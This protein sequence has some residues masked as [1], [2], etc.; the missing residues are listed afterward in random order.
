MKKFTNITI[1]FLFISAMSFA[2]TKD[3]EPV[4]NLSF[5]TIPFNRVALGSWYD[6]DYIVS[7][8]NLTEDLTI[9]LPNVAGQG[10][11]IRKF[12]ETSWQFSITLEQTNGT[13]PET[14]IEVLCAPME[15]IFYS[16]IVTH[17]SGSSLIELPVS[18]T[19]IANGENFV[20]IHP[21]EINFGNVAL[22]SD[23]IVPFFYHF[24]NENILTRTVQY[25]SAQGFTDEDGCDVIYTNA[26][27]RDCYVI[28]TPASVGFFEGDF[29]VVSP[30]GLIGTLH[31]TAY[32]VIPAISLNAENYDFG[33][34]EIDNYSPEYTYTVTGTTLVDNI[35]ITAPF[36]FEISLTSGT[37]F[38]DQ[39]ILQ[40]IDGNIEDTQIFVR[41]AP[42]TPTPFSG[43][44]LHE[45]NHGQ[46]Q[47]IALSGKGVPVGT[48]IISIN[49]I[50]LEFEETPVGSVSEE[51][52]YI[53]SAI[54]LLDDITINAPEGFEISETS[55]TNF[56][57]EIIL[58][59]GETI[60]DTEIFVRF[61]PQNNQ[62]YSDIITNIS[63][64]ATQRD[65]TVSGNGLT[66]INNIAE[67]NFTIYPNPS[68]GIFT[69]NYDA[70]R[71]YRR[72]QVKITDI[73]GKI[74]YKEQFTIHNSQ[75]TINLTN[76]PAGIY[77]LNIQTETDIYTKKII[78]Q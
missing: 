19:G 37:D 73:T 57:N 74:I 61:A 14:I 58:T 11:R 68:N 1:L 13:I 12:G 7:A 69:I 52:V 41:F 40:E 60:T 62:L 34:V 66:G 67:T 30:T 3:N 27:F 75:F 71:S 48:P 24:V 56:S 53:I 4:I 23:S 54:N 25:P 51:Q 43:N 47:T 49:K 76:Q 28:F 44:I 16:T 10:F 72:L 9:S 42:Q 64:D 77:F 55:E 70:T 5:D 18:G 33:D 39:I 38:T 29:T 26:T 6:L 46:T 31:L 36:G 8:K 20:M 2:Q 65:I 45:T 59:G 50:N 17:E 32:G 22:G 21:L 15:E 63:T 78:I 35:T